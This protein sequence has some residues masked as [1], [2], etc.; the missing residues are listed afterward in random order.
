MQLYNT[1]WRQVE[2][3]KPLKQEKVKVY[4]CWP[5]VYNFAHIGNLRTYVFEDYIIKTLKFL[6]YKLETVMNIT[7]IDD[8][9]IRDSMAS[10]EKLLD[11]TQKYTEFF[12]EDIQKLNI[13]KADHIVPISTLIPEMVEMINGLLKYGYAYLAEDWSIYFS[14]KTYKNYWKF[15]NLDMSWMQT[16]VRIDNDEYDKEQASDFVLWKSWKETDGDNFWEE[17]FEII[18]SENAT[19]E[20]KNKNTKKVTLKWRPGWHIECSA[21]NMK[22]F[23]PQIDIHMGWV[24]NIFPHHQNEI[25]QTESYTRKEFSKYW[26]HAGHLMVNGKKMSKS[27]NN[28]YTLRDIEKHF[29][30]IDKSVLYRAI[31]FS[32]M[33]GKYKDSMEFSLEKLEQC[34]NTISRVDQ[35]IKSLTRFIEENSGDLRKSRKEFSFE[36]QWFIQDFVVNLEDDFNM[37]EAFALFFEYITF[38]NTSIKDTEFCRAE[39]V[40]SLRL[41]ETF[42]EVFSIMNFEFENVEIPENILDLLTQRNEAKAW[43]DF[44][45]ADSIRSEMLEMWYKIIDDRSWTRVEKI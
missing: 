21:C 11:F 34:I 17:E 5:T 1:K 26:L 22:Y 35:T 30:K 36:L 45:K 42:N 16:S 33:N 43:K 8:K 32:F 28:F 44:A 19:L 23:W 14:V 24:D 18:D 40:A 27:A 3:F 25:A 13:Q 37:V 6:W 39:A 7:D 12:L 29:D 9:T 31:R 2:R 41:F 15:A 20:W 10:W 4:S 38:V